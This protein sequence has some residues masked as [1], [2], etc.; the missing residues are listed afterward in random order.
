MKKD[1]LFDGEAV[2]GHENAFFFGGQ[3][4]WVNG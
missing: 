4:F 3:P 2:H 1:D